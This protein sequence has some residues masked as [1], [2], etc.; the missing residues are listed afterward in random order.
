MHSLPTEGTKEMGGLSLTASNEAEAD[1]RRKEA[2]RIRVSNYGGPNGGFSLQN[3]TPEEIE[4]LQGMIE[5]RFWV[6]VNDEGRLVKHNKLSDVPGPVDDEDMMPFWTP[7]VSGQVQ[8]E[9]PLA[10]TMPEHSSPGFLIQGLGAGM[11]FAVDG[12]VRQAQILESFGFRCLRSQ[13]DPNNGRYYEIWY[14]GHFV[15][16]RGELE[17]LISKHKTLSTHEKKD[18]VIRFLCSRVRFGSLDVKWQVAALSYD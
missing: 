9:L 13:R 1:R 3:A 11:P 8:L 12:Y 16:A 15:F 7:A 2:A 5:N 4:M 14:L 6:S 17:E 10:P 18:M